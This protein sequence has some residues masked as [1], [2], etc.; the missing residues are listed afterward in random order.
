MI[1]V[2]DITVDVVRIQFVTTLPDTKL[3]A[4]FGPIAVDAGAR[5]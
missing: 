3:E 5:P 4:L 1:L 2:A